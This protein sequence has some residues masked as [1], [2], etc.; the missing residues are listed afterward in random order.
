MGAGASIPATEEAAL[1]EGYTPE[2]IAEYKT[3]LPS[4]GG[5]SAAEGGGGAAGE[6]SN[7]VESWCFGDSHQGACEA[8]GIALVEDGCLFA[9]APVKDEAGWGFLW[10]EGD[11][12]E[13]LGKVLISVASTGKVPEG[14][15]SMIT[16]GGVEYRVKDH[17]AEFE[18]GEY[19]FPV[20]QC[21]RPGRGCFIAATGGLP[22]SKIVVGTYDQ[23]KGQ[24]GG[25]CKKAICEFVHHLKGLEAGDEAA[26]GA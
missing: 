3:S 20:T 1:A 19:T 14:A 18:S 17:Q 24:E 21:V 8:A 6:W 16:I 5:T 26:A 13:A 12:A 9:A 2:Q 11:D 4:E 10:K 25:N 22:T 7:M 23:T 15:S